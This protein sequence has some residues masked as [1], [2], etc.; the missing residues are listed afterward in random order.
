MPCK[1]R[2]TVAYPLSAVGIRPIIGLCRASVH[3]F[4][5]TEL[6]AMVRVLLRLLEE[7]W[8]RVG[9]LYRIVIERS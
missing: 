5:T 6:C 1:L 8:Q 4:V 2:T 7:S 9:T 3:E